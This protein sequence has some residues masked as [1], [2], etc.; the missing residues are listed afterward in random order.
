MTHE[1]FV[2]QLLW[3]QVQVQGHTLSLSKPASSNAEKASKANTS[4]HWKI[5]LL[6][7]ERYCIKKLI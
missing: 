5:G 4:A 1:R 3:S 6:R 2:G 7:S